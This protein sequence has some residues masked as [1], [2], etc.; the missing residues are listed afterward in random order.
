[1]F[2]ELK[3]YGEIWQP[4]NE[5]EKYFCVLEFLDGKVFLETNLTSERGY[6]LELLNGTFNGLGYLTFINN[7]VI[8]GS[9][10]IIEVSKY[11]PEYTFTSSSHFI[12]P[13]LLKAKEFKIDNSAFNSWIRSFHLYDYDDKSLKKA[14]E[15]RH[16]IQIEE[17]SIGIEII[18]SATYSA[19]IESSSLLNIGIVSFISEKELT[20]MECIDLYKT[21]QKFLLFFYGKSNHFESFQLKCLG[22]DEWYSLYYKESLVK[23]GAGNLAGLDYDD[24]KE[25]L[26]KLLKNWFINEDVRFCADI[27]LENLL[28]VKVSHSRRFTNS[29][30]AFEAFS[31]RFVLIPKNPTTEKFLKT[32]K[33]L[34]SEITMKNEKDLDFFIT[35]IIR[36]RDFYIHG[37][38]KQINRFSDFELLYISFLLDFIVCIGLSEELELA[39]INIEKLKRKAKSVYID[40]QSVNKILNENNFLN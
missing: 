31:K 11:N 23:D 9:S 38:K 1:M 14:S 3:Y 17:K 21:F 2:K 8:F 15:I 37:N 5:N 22:C 33:N 7:R 30:S 25:D 32:K 39:P 26:S 19:T 27:V 24:L 35:K 40:M 18:K 20:I 6:K 28:S 16:K 12:D 36:T 4:E 34:L 13:V 29:I 10:G